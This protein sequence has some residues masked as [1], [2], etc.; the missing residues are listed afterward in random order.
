ML[1]ICLVSDFSAINRLWEL[2]RVIGKLVWSIGYF[3]KAPLRKELERA[4]TPEEKKAQPA[5]TKTAPEMEMLPKDE[6]PN[7]AKKDLPPPPP[8]VQKTK[9]DPDWPSGVLSIILH[10][11]C[12]C[13]GHEIVGCDD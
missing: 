1:M 4:L 5:P 12:H 2:T 6:A 13:G 10:Q 11:V 3:E 8:D 9:P 7:P